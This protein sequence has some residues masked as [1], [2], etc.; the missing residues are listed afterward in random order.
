MVGRRLSFLTGFIFCFL[1]MGC[2][3]FAYHFYG[4]ESVDYSHGVLLGP[5]ASDDLPFST[6]EPNAASKHPCV[7]MMTKDFYALKLDFEDTQQ[8]LKECQKG[9]KLEGG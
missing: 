6:C 7:V 5:K 3:G 8:K 4:M 9:N 1:L 2:A